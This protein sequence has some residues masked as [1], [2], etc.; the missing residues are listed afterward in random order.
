VNVFSL[1]KTTLPFLFANLFTLSLA[2]GAEQEPLGCLGGG[3]GLE[4]LR[5]QERGWGILSEEQTEIFFPKGDIRAVALVMHGLNQKPLRMNEFSRAMASHGILAVRGVLTGHGGEP[6][7]M[8]TV[9]R[10]QWLA[11]THR[12][13]CL[14]ETI[15]QKHRV[16]LV[17]IGFSL[18]ALLITDLA[19]SPEYSRIEFERVFYLAP[20]ITPSWFGRLV[21]VFRPFPSLPIPSGNRSDNRSS[22]LTPVQAYSA[23]FESSDE[24]Q[25]SGFEK[26]RFPGLVYIDPKD[27]LVSVGDLQSLI[28]KKPT[29]APWRIELVTR[30]E[31]APLKDHHHSIFESRFLG[32][33]AWDRLVSAAVDFLLK[34][35]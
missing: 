29:V 7:R 30:G 16:P 21:R 26:T 3:R 24:V 28:Q 22:F 12:A 1:K 2:R 18:G 34:K 23:L 4:F 15:A 35:S 8:K 6:E 17:G 10:E 20:A 31:D 25:K 19:T 14:A 33:K 11:D 32:K 9:T 5:S 27:E 13:Y